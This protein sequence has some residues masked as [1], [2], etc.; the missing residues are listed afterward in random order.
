M[1]VV[2]LFCNHLKVVILKSLQMLQVMALLPQLPPH[3]QL[4]YTCEYSSPTFIILLS[5]EFFESKQNM[6]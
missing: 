4:V 3:P 1:K 2:I 6:Q 5:I